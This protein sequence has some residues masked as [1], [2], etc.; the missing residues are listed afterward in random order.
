ML[1]VL[2]ADFTVKI[3]AN[4]FRRVSTVRVLQAFLP[5]P[6]F[7]IDEAFTMGLIATTSRN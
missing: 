4:R 5:T 1:T 3:C 6:R 2:T 7:W